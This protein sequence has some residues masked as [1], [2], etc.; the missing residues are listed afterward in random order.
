MQTPRVILLESFDVFDTTTISGTG[1]GRESRE[2]Y[3]V[4]ASIN[5]D[6]PIMH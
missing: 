6:A 4:E 5:S 1:G 2:H 3:Y